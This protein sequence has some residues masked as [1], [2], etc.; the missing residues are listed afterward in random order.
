MHLRTVNTIPRALAVAAATLALLVGVALEARAQAGGAL[1]RSFG[2]GGRVR[3]Q[4]GVG[5]VPSSEAFAALIQPTGHVVVAGNATGS[6]GGLQVALV[7]YQSNGDLDGAFG[8]GGSV[9]TQLGAGA[10]PSSSAVGVVRQPD[11]KLVIGGPFTD[12]FGNL[13]FGLARVEPNGVVDQTFGARGA[14]VHQ[15]GATSS[16]PAGSQ[17]IALL[18]QADGKLVMV[19]KATDRSGNDQVTIARYTGSGPDPTYGSGGRNVLQLGAGTEPFSEATAVAFARGEKTIVAGDAT[20]RAGREQVSVTRFNKGGT[21][22][23]TFASRGT[24]LVQLGLGRTPASRALAVAVLSNQKIVVAGDA[25]D[26]QG[27]QA[28]L[29]AR[30]TASGRLD[31]TFGDRGRVVAQLGARCRDCFGLSPHSSVDTIVIQPNGKILVGGQRSGASGYAF[32][33]AR[34]TSRG[35]LD[36]TFGS[37]GRLITQPALPCGSSCDTPAGLSNVEAMIRRRDGRIVVA[38][39]ATD[40]AGNNVIATARFRRQRP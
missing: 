13:A 34:F 29:V 37:R 36:R 5:Q 1:D 10:F 21:V 7:R 30:L 31:R 18:R 9:V 26:R 35:R 11:G 27:R 2:N 39:R 25:T 24:R 38:G 12:E 3:T 32:L 17:P 22:D 33:V 28:V 20:D 8:L 6:Q 40:R 15:I 4:L 19:G 16:E 23:R 14:I